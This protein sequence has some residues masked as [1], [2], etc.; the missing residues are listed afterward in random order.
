MDADDVA[1]LLLVQASL[2]DPRDLDV[3]GRI[4]D[5][6]AV[7]PGAIVA[8]LDEQRYHVRHVGARRRRDTPGGFLADQ[9]MQEGF[10]LLPGPRIGEPELAHTGT[11]HR[12]V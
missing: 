12:A 5:E 11:V 7:D 1:D 9:R 6:D 10:Q 3:F 8:S 2:P 4:H